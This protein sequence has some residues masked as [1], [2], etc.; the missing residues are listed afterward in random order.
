MRGVFD[1]S[2]DLGWIWRRYVAS[3]AVGVKIWLQRV[4]R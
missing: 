3:H 4:W 2:S 1:Q